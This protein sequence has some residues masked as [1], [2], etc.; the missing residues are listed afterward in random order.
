MK[1]KIFIAWCGNNALATQVKDCL[2]DEHYTGVVG[3]QTGQEGGFHVGE[4]VLREINQCNQAIFLVELRDDAIRGNLLFELGYALARFDAKKIHVFYINIAQ[5][6]KQIPSDLKGIW[7]NYLSSDP[8]ENAE[9]ANRDDS[10]AKQIV[11]LF[12]KNQRTII[13]EEK[14]GIIDSYYSIKEKIFRYPES[15]YC[16]EYEFAQYVLFFSLAAYMFRCEKDSRNALAELMTKLTVRSNELDCAI[17]AALCYLDIFSEIQRE[18]NTLYLKR[19]EFR[20]LTRRMDGLIENV[21]RWE[22]NDF[23]L[24]FLTF[25]CDMKNY[26]HILYSFCPTIPQNARIRCLEDSIPIAETALACCDKLVGEEKHSGIVEH[27]KN[28]Q[29]VMLFRAYMYRNLSTAYSILSEQK[30]ELKEK[31]ISSLRASLGERLQLKNYYASHSINSML[32]DN[33]EL[34]YFLAL[35]ELLEFEEDEDVQFDY[36]Q[37]CVEYVERMRSANREENYFLNKI[38]GLVGLTEDKSS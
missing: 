3:G 7:A 5:N 26:V 38:A 13:P 23:S 35:S 31:Q 30:P 14:M 1:G 16:S 18:T 19:T 21:K 22:E 6:S 28:R 11:S 34:E 32:R 25:L 2:G 37:D 20:T 24:W 8:A 17:S 15:P 33:F 4:A 29:C 12:L 36:T 9:W 10:L 27:A